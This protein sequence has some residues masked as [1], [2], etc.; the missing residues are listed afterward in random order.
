MVADSSSFPA[1]PVS[2]YSFVNPVASLAA[3]PS[4]LSGGSRLSPGLG[5]G[6]GPSPSS[7]SAGPRISICDHLG[8]LGTVCSLSVVDPDFDKDDK[9]S[10]L[11]KS[12]QE[13]IAVI[14][15]FHAFN[16][17]VSSD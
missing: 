8:T 3:P 4:T 16:P 14:T 9:E 13:M 5:T 15:Y 17:S 10:P 2:S 6:V 12:F 1:P 7:L 11:A